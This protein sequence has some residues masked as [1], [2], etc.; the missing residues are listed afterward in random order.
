[1][2]LYLVSMIALALTQSANLF[3]SQVGWIVA[4]FGFSFEFYLFSLLRE[5]K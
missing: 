4:T 2:V 3:K 1:M 5:G